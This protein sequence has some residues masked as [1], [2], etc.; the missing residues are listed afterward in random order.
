VFVGGDQTDLGRNSLTDKVPHS[1]HVGLAQHAG[2][3]AALTLN[4]ADD[5]LFTCAPSAMGFLVPM[6]VLVL[7]ADVGLI[8]FDDAHQLAE[9][10]INQ[11]GANAIAHVK[12]GRIGAETHHPMDLQA[13]DAPLASEHQVN[14]F[15]PRPHANIGVLKDGP[16]QDGEAVTASLGTSRALP[17][18]RT[19]GDGRD[20]IVVT[21]R[22]MNARRPAA[23]GQI[24][25]ARVIRRKQRLEF[26]R[27]HLPG[28]LDLAHRCRSMPNAKEY[29]TSPRFSQIPH[30]RRRDRSPSAWHANRACLAP[31]TGGGAG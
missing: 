9:I 28:K 22:A 18:K 3:D 24:S 27:R 12:R 19:V 21:T 6:P 13:A 15:E 8:D 23:R 2:Y 11:R 31:G 4:S 1:P 29:G 26:A 30:N 17:M 10:G 25:L 16:D 20:F 5:D 7:A 14:D